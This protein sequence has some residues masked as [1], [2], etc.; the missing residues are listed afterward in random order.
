M[1]EIVSDTVC[2]LLREV[3]EDHAGLSARA[4]EKTT[5]YDQFLANWDAE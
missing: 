3:E 1:S 2:T 4:K 5:S